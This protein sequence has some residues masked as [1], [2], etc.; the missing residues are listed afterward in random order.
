MAG[1]DKSSSSVSSVS[2]VAVQEPVTVAVVTDGSALT[3]ISERA[4]R[5]GVTRALSASLRRMTE[6]VESERGMTKGCL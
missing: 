1:R 2:A 4:L 5:G 3:L 6:D